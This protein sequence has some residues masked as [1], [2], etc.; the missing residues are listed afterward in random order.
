[1]LDIRRYKIIFSDSEFYVY[2]S[3]CI[4][5]INFIRHSKQSYILTYSLETLLYIW[6]LQ[7]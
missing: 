7:M 5:N 6:A 3:L 4:T 2:Q 1:M